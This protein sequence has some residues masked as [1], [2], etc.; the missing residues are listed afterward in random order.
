MNKETARFNM[1]EQ[2]I[3]TWEVL[4]PKVLN[5][6]ESVQRECFVPPAFEK[7]AFSDIEI[8]LSF[9]QK[10]MTPK[11]CARAAQALGVK[12]TDQILEIG[13]G[14]GYMSALLSSLGAT[15]TSFEINETLAETARKNLRDANIQ[16]CTVNNSDGLQTVHE[17][18]DVIMLTGAISCRKPELEKQLQIGGRMFC[19]IGEPPSMQA[20]LI[21]RTAAKGWTE[22]CL[23]ETEITSLIGAERTKEFEF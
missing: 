16:N 17:M 20:T 6:C 22:E 7:L 19:M 2:Q 21:T 15:V 13:T 11:I 1:V 8:E 9:K 10:M 3:R 14:S 12:T 4:D 18:Y 23:F 5:A